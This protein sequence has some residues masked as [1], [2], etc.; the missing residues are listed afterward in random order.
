MN[1][2]GY[3]SKEYGQ[4]TKRFVQTMQL[5]DDSEL[6]KEYRKA[7]DKDHFW[8]EIEEGIKAVGI[9]EMEIYILGDRLVMIVDAPLDFCWD[10]A[11]ARLATLPDRRNGNA[12]WRC[13]RNVPP[14]PRLTR[15][16][17]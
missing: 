6:M 16:G 5:K 10:E 4:P 1:T 8:R 14:M 12:M 17:R 7:H 3:K 2:E 13:S 15:N 9:L 11:M